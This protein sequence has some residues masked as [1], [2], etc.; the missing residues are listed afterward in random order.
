MIKRRGR[1][2]KARTLACCSLAFQLV[3][4][5]SCSCTNISCGHHASLSLR[6]STAFCA[7][8]VSPCRSFVQYVS[9][10]TSTCT[11]RRLLGREK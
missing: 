6:R 8:T 7:P 9:P 3:W 1:F 10:S 2:P 5:A 4:S 11:Q